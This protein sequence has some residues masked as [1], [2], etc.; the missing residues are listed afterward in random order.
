MSSVLIIDDDEMLNA[1]LSRLVERTGHN[2]VSALTIRDGVD[3]AINGNFDVVFLD[4]R[5]PDGN[6]LEALPKIKKVASEPEIIII[7]G[8]SDINGAEIAFES[9]AWDYMTKPASSSDMKLQLTRALQYREQKQAKSEPYVFMN[10]SII[11]SSERWNA[12]LKQLSYAAS[13]DI[14]TLLTGETGTGKELAART[15]HDNNARNKNQFVVVDCTVLPDTLVESILFG[16]EAGSFTGATESRKGLVAL[17]DGGTLF[18]DEIGEMPL[19]IQRRFLRVLQE[20][21]FRP[22]GSKHEVSSDFRLIAAT[23]KD[24]HAMVKEGTFREDLLYRISGLTLELPPL[25]ERGSDVAYLAMHFT[26]KMCKEYKQERKGFAPECLE[27]LMQYSWPG[28]VREL[29]NTIEQIV[30]S[31]GN[32]PILYP[33]HLPT[34]MRLQLVGDSIKSAQAPVP[35]SNGHEPSGSESMPPAPQIDTQLSFKEFREKFEVLY[36][37]KL[38]GETEY[39]ISLAS[40]SAGLSRTRFYQLLKKYDLD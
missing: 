10:N 12:V 1:A 19:D 6:G 39:N 11:G 31:S 2:A 18:L 34:H 17:A 3:K 37:K 16:H 40:K 21:V 9:G 32:E 30:V 26:E 27:S 14:S 35:E 38:L 20:H 28:N 29:I 24:L 22:V 23:N 33:H 5:L 15:I 7:T 36:L 8:F 13:S 25:R 4:V